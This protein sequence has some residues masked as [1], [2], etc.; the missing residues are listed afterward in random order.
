M[1]NNIEEVNKLGWQKE[2]P[3]KHMQS[4]S[5]QQQI[6][7]LRTTKAATHMRCGSFVFRVC[8]CKG[9]T[10][11]INSG[12]DCVSYQADWSELA[13]VANRFCLVAQL[14]PTDDLESVDASNGMFQDT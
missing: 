7:V 4:A 3:D 8:W 5:M 2:T 9:K 10:Y 13:R 14:I 11:E 12:L 1:R 6:E